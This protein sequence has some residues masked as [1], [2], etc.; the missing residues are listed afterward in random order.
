L[1][2]TAWGPPNPSDVAFAAYQIFRNYDGKG[3]QFFPTSIQAVVSGSTGLH[4]FSSVG[5]SSLTTVVVNENSA[6]SAQ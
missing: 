4:A 1:L 6:I 5:S 2:A 3:S